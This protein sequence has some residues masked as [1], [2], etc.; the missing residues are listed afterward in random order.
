MSVIQ[1]VLTVS[2]MNE[3][4]K[5]KATK[6]TNTGDN[7]VQQESKQPEKSVKDQLIGASKK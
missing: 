1:E 5:L 6:K 4:K 2:I 7:Q 3:S